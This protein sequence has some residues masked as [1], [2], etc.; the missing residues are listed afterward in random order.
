V[1][2]WCVVVVLVAFDVNGWDF[3]I[4]CSYCVHDLHLYIVVRF[5]EVK[6][7]WWGGSV[8]I[9]PSGNDA[10]VITEVDFDRILK[11]YFVVSYVVEKKPQ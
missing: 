7:I 6:R 11:G 10:F 8:S 3:C 2:N 4:K 5:E 1:L 9:G